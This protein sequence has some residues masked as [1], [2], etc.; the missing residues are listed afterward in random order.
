MTRPDIIRLK[1]EIGPKAAI[2]L[3][4]PREDEKTREV[5]LLNE[6]GAKYYN[7][8]FRPDSALYLKE[9]TELY[10]NLSNMGEVYLYRIR[11]EAFGKRI[12]EALEIIAEQENHPAVFHCSIG[13]DRTGVLAAIVLAA[14][15]VVDEDIIE[16]YTLTAPFMK[17][18]RNRVNNDPKTPD[19]IKNLP[20]FTW[21]AT[22]ESMSLF[23]SLLRQ[24]YGFAKGYL[25]AHGADSS[26]ITRL[27][28]A[29]L[30]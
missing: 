19:D 2:D 8:P 11:H 27:E 12:T 24:E 22:P 17:E 6:M 1:K 21:E 20:D 23:L 14:V 29:L 18:I 25:E 3:R 13:K 10:R 5:S 16:D 9:E 7:I 15:G 28:K 4:T 30:A 26:L